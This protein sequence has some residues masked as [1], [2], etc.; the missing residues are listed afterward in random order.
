MDIGQAERNAEC[1]MN[2]VPLFS[3]GRTFI[4]H[5]KVNMVGVCN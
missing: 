1:G 2:S 3:R 4:S 5:A